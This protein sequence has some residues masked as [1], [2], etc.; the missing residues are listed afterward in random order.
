MPADAAP[1]TGFVLH[2]EQV[3]EPYRVG[4]VADEQAAVIGVV[5]AQVQH[6]LLLQQPGLDGLD[7]HQ[8]HLR[9]APVTASP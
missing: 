8:V 2:Q 1:D 3:V 5:D 6:E 7:L 9:L 4:Q